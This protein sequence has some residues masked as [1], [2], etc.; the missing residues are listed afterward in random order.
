[1]PLGME[2]GLSP[3]DIVLDGDPAPPMEL[4]TAASPLFG[5]CLLWP[6]GRPSQ[7]L[8]SCCNPCICH[9]HTSYSGVLSLYVPY[10]LTAPCFALY[11]NT[12]ISRSVLVGKKGRRRYSVLL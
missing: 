2:V 8:L 3:G 5:S 1:V 7:Q 12:S 9:C 6:N 4:G 10:P 11:K